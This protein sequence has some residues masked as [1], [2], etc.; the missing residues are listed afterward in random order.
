M[1]TNLF[2]LEL[3]IATVPISEVNPSPTHPE[4]QSLT[5]QDWESRTEAPYLHRRPKLPP[6]TEESTR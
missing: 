1:F 5:F 6:R 4:R 3:V 2:W